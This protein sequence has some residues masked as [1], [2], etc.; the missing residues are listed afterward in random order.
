MA[1]N[2][3]TLESKSSGASKSFNNPK[4]GQTSCEHLCGCGLLSDL[5]QNLSVA[6]QQ[7]GQ[8]FNELLDALQPPLL[9]NGARL[10]SDGLWDGVSGQIFQGGGQV[11]RRQHAGSETWGRKCGSAR[12]STRRKLQMKQR[13]YKKEQRG[14]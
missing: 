5:I 2:S 3:K 13:S 6:G 9:H 11:E 12:H 14:K 10:L 8:V 7:L 4:R 1:G